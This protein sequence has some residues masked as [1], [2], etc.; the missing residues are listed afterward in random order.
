MNAKTDA[1]LL[2][3]VLPL[4]SLGSYAAAPGYTEGSSKPVELSKTADYSKRAQALDASLQAKLVGRWTNPVDKV[5]I[6][7]S[8]VDLTSGQLKGMEWAVTGPAAGD[9]HDLV[10]WV[11]Q[12]PPKEGF[13]N[14][15]P[16]SFSTTLYEYGTLPVWAGFIQGDQILTVHYLIWPNR[17]YTWDHISTFTETWSRMP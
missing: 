7:I 16:V 6:E 14:V 15:I 2:L 13:D 9:E 12:A 3:L 8:S 5:I 1:K 11:N 17:T 4:L 10:G